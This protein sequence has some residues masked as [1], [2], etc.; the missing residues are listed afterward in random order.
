[1]G[2]DL[3]TAAKWITLKPPPKG[4]LGRAARTAGVGLPR[5]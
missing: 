5:R 2:V 4:G 1:M 3:Q